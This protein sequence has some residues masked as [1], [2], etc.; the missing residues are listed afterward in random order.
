MTSLLKEIFHKSK[1]VQNVLIILNFTLFRADPLSQSPS[2]QISPQIVNAEVNPVKPTVVN[3][4]VSLSENPV[5]IYFVMDLSNSMRVHQVTFIH[6][7]T[8]FT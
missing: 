2:V 7:S 3:F 6:N 5:D 8:L 4:E 1:L